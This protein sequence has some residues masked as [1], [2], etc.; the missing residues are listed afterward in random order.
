MRAADPASVAKPLRETQTPETSPEYG[1]LAVI[2]LGSRRLCGPPSLGGQPLR[3]GNAT[4]HS[5]SRG[6]GVGASV[7]RV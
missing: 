6:L 3:V 1:L 2:E 5:G 4:C 7:G